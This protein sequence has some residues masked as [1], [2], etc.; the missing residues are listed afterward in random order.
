MKRSTIILIILFGCCNLFAQDI[1]KQL[2][3]DNRTKNDKQFI[4]E[5]ITLSNKLN[6]SLNINLNTWDTIYIIQGSEITTG[7]GFGLIWKTNIKIDYADYKRNVGLRK[8]LASNPQ[9]RVNPVTDSFSDFI[10]LIPYIE[11][12]DTSYIK[13]YVRKVNEHTSL[14]GGVYSWR[15]MK[16]EKINL[17]YIIDEFWVPDFVVLKHHLE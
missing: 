16:L 13:Q 7:A 11:K 15:I 2:K 1:V 4:N 3:R 10:D 12:W 17:R 14:L 9:I 8:P 5:I 6:D